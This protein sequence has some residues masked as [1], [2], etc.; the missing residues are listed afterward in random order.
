M[1]K[2]NEGNIS[3][4]WDNW[5][6]IGALAGVVQLDEPYNMKMLRQVRI[7]RSILFDELQE[8]PEHIIELIQSCKLG[9][10]NIADSTIWMPSSNGLF[11]TF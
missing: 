7:G 1:W 3:L 2:Y 9:D 10:P 8:F 6:G 4:W 11:T 5:L